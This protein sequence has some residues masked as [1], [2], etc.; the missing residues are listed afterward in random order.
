MD[1][2][3]SKDLK[4]VSQPS[5]D[6]GS[7]DRNRGVHVSRETKLLLNEDAESPKVAGYYTKV[8]E[9]KFMILVEEFFILFFSDDAAKII[10]TFHER[11]G[12]KEFRCSSWYKHKQFGHARELSFQHPIKIYF[13]AKSGRCQKDQK[14]RVYRSNHLVIE[15]SQEV[16]EVPYRD[17]FHVEGLWDVENDGDEINKSC[18]LRRSL[19]K[20]DG[21]TDII[22]NDEVQPK[23][24][25]KRCVVPETI[26]VPK[27]LNSQLECSSE[28]GTGH[29]TI[30]L[31][32]T[33]SPQVHLVSQQE[34]I[35]GNGNNVRGRAKDVAWLEKQFGSRD[36][37]DVA[38]GVVQ[39]VVGGCRRKVEVEKDY[40]KGLIIARNL[41]FVDSDVEDKVPKTPEVLNG[42]EVFKDPLMMIYEGF[43]PKEILDELASGGFV[44]VD[45]VFSPPAE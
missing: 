17:Y 6:V 9:S 4:T 33:R 27:N 34:N 30:I 38:P 37:K 32:L 23:R 31:L 43:L 28:R 36:G 10:E 35:N 12:D 2:L 45:D 13:G 25:D 41:E 16:S 8:A 42:M 7:V 1:I 14:F 21:P 19:T 44:K 3:Y 26:H 39:Q 22:Q 15:T 11:C 5:N 40:Y 29:L 18:I 20:L 24:H